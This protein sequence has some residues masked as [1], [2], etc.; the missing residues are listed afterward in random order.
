MYGLRVPPNEERAMRRWNRRDVVDDGE[1][2]RNDA[3]A[4]VQENRNPFVDDPKL[5]GRIRDF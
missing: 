3:I 2:A 5:I 1:R 4:S